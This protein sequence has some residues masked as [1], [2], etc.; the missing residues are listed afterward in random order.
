M[1][2]NNSSPHPT[3]ESAAPVPL[4]QAN[5]FRL[6]PTRREFDAEYP[7][8]PSPSQS[9]TN[10]QYSDE[11]QQSSMQSLHPKRANLRFELPRSKPLFQGF[12]KPNFSRVA[13]L[14]VLC[15]VT[16]P[17]FH[18]LTFVAKD[19]SLFIVRLIVSMW[20]S[21]VGFALGYMLLRI[22]AQHLEAASELWLVVLRDFLSST[23]N[24]LG[25]CDSHGSQRWRNETSQSGQKLE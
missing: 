5:S 19:I 17:A 16:Y 12:E 25:H 18:I 14:A 6:T 20:C 22:G 2:D 4:I 21:G 24:S 23:L 13:I 15:L 3:E 9:T 11:P 1:R 10:F 8:W 7:A